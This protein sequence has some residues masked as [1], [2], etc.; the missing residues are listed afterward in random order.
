MKYILAIDQST[1]G[2]KGIIIGTD[3]RI[4]SRQD[5]SHRQITNDK[6]WIE[7]DPMEIFENV[8]RVSKLTVEKAGIT[9]EE[10]TAVGISNQRE[11]V[12]AWD[13]KTGKPVCN[14][15]VWQCGRAADIAAELEPYAEEIRTITGLQ[16]SPYFP[17]RKW[18]GS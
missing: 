9:T 11:T 1:A 10:L 16:L 12:V 8:L 15:V 13:R 2:T 17:V 14:A 6:G 4:I 18:P 5:I 3:G 7:H